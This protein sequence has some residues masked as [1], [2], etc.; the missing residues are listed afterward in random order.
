M[1]EEIIRVNLEIMKKQRKELD[2]RIAE[3]ENLLETTPEK[4]LREKEIGLEYYYTLFTQSKDK[5]DLRL[6]VMNKKSLLEL[7]N[8]IGFD[9]DD[10]SKND[11]IK[12]ISKR[13]EVQMNIGKAFY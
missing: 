11:L 10:M 5:L 1:N 9:A 7:A 4:V 12:N 3:L 13:I 6:K 8:K 2:D